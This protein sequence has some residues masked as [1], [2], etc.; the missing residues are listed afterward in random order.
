MV[1]LMSG[2]PVL[3][4]GVGFVVLLV[5]LSSRNVAVRTL[6]TQV[7][8][9]HER[10]R[11]LSLQSSVRYLAA[12]IGSLAS[13]LVLETREDGALDGMVG[14]GALVIALS[15]GVLPLLWQ[16]ERRVKA[17]DQVIL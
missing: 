8:E 14:L 5:S 12:G 6:T 10:A 11:Y 7:P 1:Y 4:V 13:S 9:A 16:V 2:E 15:L 17:R 3:P